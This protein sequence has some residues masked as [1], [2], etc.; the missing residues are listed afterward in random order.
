MNK[1]K[2]S[3][4]PLAMCCLMSPALR[5]LPQ[6]MLWS[7]PLWEV[8]AMYGIGNI[9]AM[10]LMAAVA[11]RAGRCG[12]ETVRRVGAVALPIMVIVLL[13]TGICGFT[14]GLSERFMPLAGTNAISADVLAMSWIFAWFFDILKKVEKSEKKC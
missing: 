6:T 13:W 1:T 11:I 9:T 2:T 8:G 3:P 14:T 7:P 5:L 10:V 12:S 4:V